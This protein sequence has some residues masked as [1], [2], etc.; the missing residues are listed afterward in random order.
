MEHLWS[1]GP[2]ALRLVEA[3]VVRCPAC[4][5]CPPCTC[6]AVSCALTCAGPASTSLIV[7]Q[8]R[9]WLG[10][11]A[12]FLFG[13]ALLRCWDWCRVAYTRRQKSRAEGA[14]EPPA[15]ARTPQVPANAA[16]GRVVPVPEPPSGVMERSLDIKEFQ[17]LVHFPDDANGFYW[18]MRI[19]LVRAGAAGVWVTLTPTLELFTHDLSKIRHIVLGRNAAWPARV[20]RNKIFSFDPIT[21]AKLNQFIQLARAQARV[22]AD[23]DMDA[24]APDMIWLRAGPGLEKLGEVVPQEVV[25][26]QGRF[27][28]IGDSAVA[29]VNGAVIWA[30]RVDAG[31]REAWAKER[32]AAERDDRIIGVHLRNGKRS[33]LL[34]EALA[35]YSQAGG[36]EVYERSWQHDSGVYPGLHHHSQSMADECCQLFHL[37]YPV[38]VG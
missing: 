9:D 12:A 7:V 33:I 2:S 10:I 38:S 30:A 35:L 16:A 21:R 25:D 26:D 32:Q 36:F 24:E 4:P 29:E 37:G 15:P 22:L 3:A 8:E 6:P 34:K 28:E 5:A 19:L 14:L 31:E 23:D 11:S 1:L 13:I 27:S 18:H 20:N 17:V